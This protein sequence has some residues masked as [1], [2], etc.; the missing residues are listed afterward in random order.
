MKNIAVIFAG[1]T[2]SRMGS[3]LPKQFLKVNGN[4]I[5]IHT[6]NRFEEN[7]NIDEIYIACIEEWLTYLENIIAR[8]GIRKVKRVF[9]GG[10]TG[11]DSIFIGLSEVLKDHDNAIVLIHDGVRPLITDEVINNCIEKVKEYGNAITATPCFETPITSQDGV[12]V[13]TMPRRDT[14]YTAQAPQCFYLQD[15]YKAHLEERAI[16]PNYE[17]IVD[18]CGLMFKHGIKC[19]LIKGNRGNIKVTTPEDF[20]TLISNLNAIDY[21]QFLNLENNLNEKSKGKEYVLKKH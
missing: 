21:A 10:K 12:L 3:S 13:E 14:V 8:S 9:K 16:N 6:L 1:G 19:H 5:I 20:C 4:E 7:E 18:S 17:G 15:I 11:Q 2:G